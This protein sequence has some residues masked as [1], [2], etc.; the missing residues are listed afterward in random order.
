M[1]V[2]SFFEH[3][4]T[5]NMFDLGESD[6][7]NL[8]MQPGHALLGH[9]DVQYNRIQGSHESHGPYDMGHAPVLLTSTP[10]FSYI[11]RLCLQM[12]KLLSHLH[13]RL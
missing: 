9:F 1:V 4:K 11:F 7:G 13:E 12:I 10:E 2:K 3:R 8:L 6:T 5:Q